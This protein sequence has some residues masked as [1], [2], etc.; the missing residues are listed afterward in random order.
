MFTLL[1]SLGNLADNIDQWD[2]SSE[3]TICALKT[4]IT[5][6]AD[7]LNTAF[8]PL[9]ETPD[10]MR[11][12]WWEAHILRPLIRASTI[13]RLSSEITLAPKTKTLLQFMNELAKNPLGFAVQLRVVES[14]SLDVVLFLLSLFTKFEVNGQKIFKSSEALSWITAHIEDK[15]LD[16]Q[17]TLYEDMDR[18]NMVSTADQ[19]DLFIL[20]DEY[21]S[22]WRDALDELYGFLD[23]EST[24]DDC[25]DMA[26]HLL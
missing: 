25:P 20:A 23:G 3:Y 10:G 9:Q 16:D 2:L 22:F 18:M 8:L 12:V 15:L 19:K 5:I 6:L 13:S 26:C 11:Y 21:M 4:G 24:T 1:I 7:D 14:I 17:E